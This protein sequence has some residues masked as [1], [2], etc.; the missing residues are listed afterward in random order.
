MGAGEKSNYR[1][2]TQ[3]LTCGPSLIYTP[4]FIV[5]SSK[6]CSSPAAGQGNTA[7][8]NPISGTVIE[9]RNRINIA[10]QHHMVERIESNKH[11]GT[12]KV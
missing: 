10:L 2:G 12:S 9:E 3:V 4:G 7:S 1:N 6:S 8:I 11:V 5:M